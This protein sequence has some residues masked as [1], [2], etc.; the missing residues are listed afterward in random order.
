MGSPV[1]TAAQ[2]EPLAVHAATCVGPGA[3]AEPD[4]F[5]ATISWKIMICLYEGQREAFPREG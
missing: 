5:S 1:K 2:L 4:L 3:P